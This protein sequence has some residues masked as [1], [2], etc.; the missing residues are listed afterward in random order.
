MMK[1][2]D[3]VVSIWG[4]NSSLVNYKGTLFFSHG[5]SRSESQCEAME[6]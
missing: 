1:E 4:V 6:R 3:E 5:N 2:R